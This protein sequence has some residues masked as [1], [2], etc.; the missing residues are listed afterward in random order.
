MGRY[1]AAVITGDTGRS[2]SPLHRGHERYPSWTGF[3]PMFE[4]IDTFAASR[5]NPVLRQIQPATV[6]MSLSDSFSVSA[7]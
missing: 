3:A 7:Q 5:G 4:Q 6:P 2:Q 1:D